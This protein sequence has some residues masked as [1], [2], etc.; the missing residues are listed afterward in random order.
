MD[1]GTNFP[2]FPDLV[3]QDQQTQLDLQDV[4]GWS[5]GVQTSQ[6]HLI[7]QDDPAILAMR[8]KVTHPNFDFDYFKMVLAQEQ[9]KFLCF[10]QAYKS[11][12]DVRQVIS[13]LVIPEQTP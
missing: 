9:T 1:V 12:E 7:N 10:W 6:S 5:R 4:E 11:F 2:D 3:D 8:R 13:S